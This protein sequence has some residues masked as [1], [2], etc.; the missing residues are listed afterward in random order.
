MAQAK[1]EEGVSGRRLTL[2][3]VRFWPLTRA[4]AGAAPIQAL[5]TLLVSLDHPDG[6]ALRRVHSRWAKRVKLI[7]SKTQPLRIAQNQSKI[8]VHMAHSYSVPQ[9][10]GSAFSP[11]TMGSQGSALNSGALAIRRGRFVV[12]PVSIWLARSGGLLLLAGHG[13][14]AL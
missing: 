9:V 1:A 3:V 2:M 14:S 11:F 7:V 13:T 8:V 6:E 5:S 4:C 12:I 10:L